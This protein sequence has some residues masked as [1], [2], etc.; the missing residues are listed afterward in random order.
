MIRSGEICAKALIK[1]FS[2]AEYVLVVR[3]ESEADE[4]AEVE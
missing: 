1:R 2:L 4:G 3:T